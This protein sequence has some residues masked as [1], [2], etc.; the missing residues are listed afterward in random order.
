MHTS[1]Y[2]IECVFICE[3]ALHNLQD[4]CKLF[5]NTKHSSRISLYDKQ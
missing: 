1:I 4:N 2:N 5:S 3:F